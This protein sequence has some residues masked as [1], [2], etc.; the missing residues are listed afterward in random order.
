M[1]QIG[2]WRA[3]RAGMVL[4]WRVGQSWPEWPATT[5]LYDNNSNNGARYINTIWGMFWPIQGQF[6]GFFIP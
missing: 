3:A 1:P 2:Q 6:G 5:P 4:G